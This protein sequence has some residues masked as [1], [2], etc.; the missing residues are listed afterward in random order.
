M[1]L[2]VFAHHERMQ[3]TS[4]FSLG[5]KR[6][7]RSELVKICVNSCH[8]GSS[9]Q[10]EIQNRQLD[11]KPV[12]SCTNLHHF[13]V[14]CTIS[15]QYFFLTRATFSVIF[16]SFGVLRS[17]DS[18]VRPSLQYSNTPSLR[19]VFS[20]LRSFRYLLFKISAPPLKSKIKNHNRK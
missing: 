11:R 5:M 1:F 18:V 15:H 2:H 14:I 12:Q 7:A 6:A 8:A 10:S 13:A 16:V 20:L 9:S 17:G 3:K 4:R 19:S